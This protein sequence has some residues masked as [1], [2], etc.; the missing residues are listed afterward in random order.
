MIMMMMKKL[1]RRTGTAERRET[2]VRL[3][4]LITCGIYNTRI[5]TYTI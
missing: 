1:E 2:L 5:I 3:V 4:R